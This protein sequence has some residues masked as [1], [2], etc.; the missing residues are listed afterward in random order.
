ML[1]LLYNLNILPTHFTH[2]H[3][4]KNTNY[5]YLLIKNEHDTN[6]GIAQSS[7]INTPTTILP[8][9]AP[10]FPNVEPID[11]AMPLKTKYEFT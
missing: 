3:T 4:F 8:I 9:S 2:H 5:V 10:T 11:T 7:S 1:Y 6:I